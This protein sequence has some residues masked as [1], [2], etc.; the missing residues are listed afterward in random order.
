MCLF[1]YSKHHPSV[2]LLFIVIVFFSF[3]FPSIIQQ[4]KN[5]KQHVNVKLRVISRVSIGKV[6]DLFIKYSYKDHKYYKY[7]KYYKDHS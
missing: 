7:Y 2:Q 6:F 5:V 1:I 4:R 3:S